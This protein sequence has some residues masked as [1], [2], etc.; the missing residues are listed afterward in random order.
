MLLRG[1]NKTN[2]VCLESV[3][4]TIQERFSLRPDVLDPAPELEISR[5]KFEEIKRARTLLSAALAIEEK[6]EILYCNYIEY[7]Q[8]LLLGALDNTAR[9]DFGYDK[10]FHVIALFN[11]RIINI[12]TA[13]RM[14]IDQMV[15]NLRECLLEE[16]DE[17]V[18]EF[19]KKQTAAKYEGSFEYA[20]MEA[21][22]NHAQHAGLCVSKVT[23][24]NRNFAID[25]GG[26]LWENRSLV[27]CDKSFLESNSRFKSAILKV[28]PEKVDLTVAIRKYMA[29]LSEIHH[30][31]RNKIESGVDSARSLIEEVVEQYSEISGGAFKFTHANHFTGESESPHEVVPL[32]L[33]WDNIRKDLQKRNL[34]RSNISRHYVSSRTDLTVVTP[35]GEW[36]PKSAS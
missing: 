7:E 18:K 30:S 20:F 6:Y 13:A 27:Y 15:G 21:L 35:T 9:F 2:Y 3:E 1:Y 23:S 16:T 19:F 5:E 32:F 28:M 8:A 36:P 11:R 12:L 34:Q 29:C 24:D 33:D 4:V 22:R 10:A 14:Y 26:R 17:A 31:V 25:E